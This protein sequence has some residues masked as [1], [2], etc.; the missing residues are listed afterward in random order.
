MKSTLSLVAALS[1][2]NTVSAWHTK[3]SGHRNIPNNPTL[4]R[5]A[6]LFGSQLQDTGDVQYTTN[7]TVNGVNF[8]VIAD[9]GSADLYVCTFTDVPNSVDT[10]LTSSL[11]FAV[12]EVDGPVKTASLNFANYTVNKQAYLQV[13][14]DNTTNL[15]GTGL[16]GLGPSAGSNILLA[17]GGRAAGNTPL[18]NIF[19]QNTSTPNFITVLLGRA[20]EPTNPFP[21]DLTVGQTLP[22]YDNVTSQP[23]LPVTS[24]PLGDSGNQHWQVLLD[25]QGAFINGVNIPMNTVVAS[26]SNPNQATA[27]FDSGFSLP[28]VPKAVADAFYENVKG[29]LFTNVVGLGKAWTLPCSAEVNI[30]FSFGGVKFPIHPLDASL[31]TKDL[32]IPDFNVNGELGCIG[33]FQPV[34]FDADTTFDMVLGMAFL[35]N[36]YMLIN[37]GDFVDGTKVTAQPYIQLLPLTTDPVAAHADFLKVRSNLAPAKNTHALAVGF[38]VLIILL[39]LGAAAIGGAFWFFCRRRRTQPSSLSQPIQYAQPAYGQPAYGQPAYGQPVSYGQPQPQGGYPG[40]QTGY[41]APAQGY[42]T[43]NA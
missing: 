34:S 16:I 14:A 3:I 37:F 12:G 23:K 11:T 17:F 18:D 27:V 10:G 30:S 20:D 4:G 31:T 21:G 24:N 35:R 9:T 41:P 15:P 2:L 36:A 26:T 8:N 29:A 6:T 1:L 25:T 5:R 19:L 28:Q 22:Q 38:I 13:T 42:G 39:L 43:Y 33:A 32:Q 40:Q 7:L